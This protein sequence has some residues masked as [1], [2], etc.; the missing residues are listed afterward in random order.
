MPQGGGDRSQLLARL[1]PMFQPIATTGW[2][3]A[4]QAALKAFEKAVAIGAHFH[5]HSLSRGYEYAKSGNQEQ[6]RKVIDQLNHLPAYVCAPCWKAYVHLA[7]GENDVALV[8]LEKAYQE[9][10]GCL[11]DL[12]VDRDWDPLQSK[13]RASSIC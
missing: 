1:Q 12:K 6:A 2:E 3:I 13:M 5:V 10:S 4:E 9:R 8:L 7:L 11:T